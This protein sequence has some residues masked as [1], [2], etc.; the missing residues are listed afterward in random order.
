MRSLAILVVAIAMACDLANVEPPDFSGLG[1]LAEEY[2]EQT[3]HVDCGTVYACE[4]PADNEL[5]RVEYCWAHDVRELEAVHGRCAPSPHERF[6]VGN[7]CLWCC[8][9]TCAIQACNA[10]SGCWCPP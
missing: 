3:G 7:V 5:G 1:Q 2:C 9:A 8:D 6:D 4:T 10:F